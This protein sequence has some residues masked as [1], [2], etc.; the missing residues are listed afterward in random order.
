MIDREGRDRIACALRRFA[1][2]RL[3][4]Y[5]FD[6]VMWGA[7]RSA[8]SAKVASTRPFAPSRSS[9]SELALQR[10]NATTIFA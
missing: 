5:E 2:G 10:T 7:A 6:R 9:A 3:H 1:S 8:A 4:R